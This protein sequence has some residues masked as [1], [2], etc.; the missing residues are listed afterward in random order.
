MYNLLFV[1]FPTASHT[2]DFKKSSIQHC[3]MAR[4]IRYLMTKYYS[5]S[6][7]N[8]H[9]Q[10]HL[11]EHTSRFVKCSCI[12]FP[13]YPPSSVSFP[14]FLSVC[15]ALLLFSPFSLFQMRGISF[16]GKAKKMEGTAYAYFP[17]YYEFAYQKQAKTE[18]V[19]P[20]F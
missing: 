7:N 1:F 17:H 3:K 11:F 18:K 6:L 15:N 2:M 19:A 9:I 4:A 20:F 12:P 10:I 5:K 16:K 13:L 14:L 8:M